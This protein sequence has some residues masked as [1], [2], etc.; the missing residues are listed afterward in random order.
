MFK[1]EK[2]MLALGGGLVVAWAVLFYFLVSPMWSEREATVARAREKLERLAKLTKGSSGMWDIT[3]ANESLKNEAA[4]LQTMLAELKA[5]EAGDL[6]EYDI[7]KNTGDPATYFS[8]LRKEL[9]EK[10]AESPRVLLAPAIENDLG[11]RDKAGSDPVALNLTRLHVLEQFFAAAKAA[12]VRE[13]VAI[14]YLPPTAMPRPA[15]LEIESLIQIPIAV[16]MRLPE[17]SL[18]PL[19]YELE[20]NPKAGPA[21][22]YF[23]IRALQASVKDDKAG[24]LDA[25]INVGALYTQAQ[26]KDQG[27]TVKEER[28]SLGTFS[29]TFGGD[30]T[31]Y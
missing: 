22:R 4:A 25:A 21:N 12:G 7:R 13:V 15:G 24:V 16:Q 18:G 23:C 29:R 20:P 28:P 31:R 11:F 9:I 30:S 3:K 8:R 6:G 17:A 27:V 19:L 26:M 10:I 5:V 2:K 1:D 14:Q